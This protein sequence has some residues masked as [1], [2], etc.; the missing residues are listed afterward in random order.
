VWG[1][2]Q[3]SPGETDAAQLV[4]QA[5]YESFAEN[6]DPADVEYIPRAAYGESG[7]VDFLL[8]ASYAAPSVLPDLA[9]VDPFEIRYLV[10]EGLAQ[11]V[12]GVISEELI[13]DLYPFARVACT[14]DG[15]LVCL[16]FEADIEH[17]VYY[18]GALEEPPVTWADLF[19]EAISYTFPAAGVDGLVNDTFLIQYLAQGGQFLNEQGDPSL[20]DSA[21]QRVLRLYNAVRRWD[22]SPPSILELATLEDCWKA[23]TGGNITVSHISSRQYLASRTA[24]RETDF[25]AVPTETGV[26]ATMSRGWAFVILAQSPER[27]EAAADLIEWLMLPENLSQWSEASNHLPTRRSALPLVGW[28]REYED[29]LDDQ[30]GSAFYR[31]SGT[32][33]QRVARALQT[34]VE[35]VLTE[36]LTP[37]EATAQVMDSLE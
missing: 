18:T 14:S 34:A 4:L 27:R 30:L 29:F 6:K 8:D 3:F 23:Y 15:E 7:V 12:R 35:A 5:Q 24:M 26:T 36:E 13:Q 2:L 20:D 19:T 31:P 16:Q 10:Q 17:V 32:Q 25:A 37:R 9:I 22:V 33:F 11:P 21:V 28:P 1:P